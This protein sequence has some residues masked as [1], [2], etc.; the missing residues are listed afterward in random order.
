MPSKRRGVLF[1]NARAGSFSGADE[2]ELRTRAY[3]SGLRVVDVGPDVDVGEIVRTSIGAGLRS[4]VVAGGDGSIHHVVQALVGTE[5][6]LG[7]LPIGTVNHLAR[8]LE[9]P[10]DWRAAFDVALEGEVRQIDVGRANGIYFLNS[11]MVGLYPT[12]TEYR[13]RFRSTHSKWRAYA[14]SARLA[15]R[16]FHH[17]TL[18]L[19]H[20]DRMETIRTQMFAVSVNSYDLTQAGIAA[21]KTTFEDGRLTIYTLSVPNRMALVRA[22]A[23]FFRGRVGEVEGFRGIRT[24]QLRIDTPNPTLRVSIDGELVDATTPLQIA[25]VPAGLLVR[26]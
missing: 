14:R 7:I 17:V 20:D 16:R 15:L 9:L 10:F 13:E 23:K 22:A 6:V 3:D 1:L 2:S 11:V 4:I 21:P 12:L 26:A 25:A 19:E 24:R 18:V 8:D 5:G